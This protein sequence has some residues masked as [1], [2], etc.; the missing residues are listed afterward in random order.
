MGSKFDARGMEKDL[1]SDAVPG[2]EMRSRHHGE[3]GRVPVAWAI[4]GVGDVG[5]NDKKT[6][7]PRV[8]MPPEKR[9]LAAPSGFAP[10]TNDDKGLRKYPFVDFERLRKDFGDVVGSILKYH[11]VEGVYQALN[12]EGNA[13]TGGIGWKIIDGVMKGMKFGYKGN[14]KN[15][16]PDMF[17]KIAVWKRFADSTANIGKLYTVE[18]SGFEFPVYITDSA[19]KLPDPSME[20][21]SKNIDEI[22]ETGKSPYNSIEEMV[23]FYNNDFSRLAAGKFTRGDFESSMLEDPRQFRK[24]L[25]RDQTWLVQQYGDVVDEISVTLEHGAT[26]KVRVYDSTSSMTNWL[27]WAVGDQI[28][29]FIDAPLDPLQRKVEGYSRDAGQIFLKTEYKAISG[30]TRAFFTSNR[31]PLL[32]D[33]T[34]LPKNMVP[35]ITMYR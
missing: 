17:P 18:M 3:N 30:I 20:L 7:K 32:Y 25:M 26:A 12:V 9:I 35:D 1:F 6:D 24:W 16:L 14:F 19:G 5:E 21:L 4:P 8:Q 10:G 29:D 27:F 13:E 23:K 31:L 2:R 28:Y 15:K 22:A 11:L 33:V 34:D